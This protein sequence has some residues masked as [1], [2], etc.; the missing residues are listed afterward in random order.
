MRARP[1]FVVCCAFVA[2]A[3]M[4]MGT[5]RA[6]NRT[7]SGPREVSSD[8]RLGPL[9]TLN[10]EFSFVPSPTPEAWASRAA[11]LR[12]QIQVALGLWP[13]PDRPPLKPVIHGA[14]T[15]EGYTVER[16]YFQSLP[17]FFVTG[18]LYRPTGRTGKLPAVLSPHGHWASFISSEISSARQS[19]A[20]R[21][22]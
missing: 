1:R 17:G 7:A 3:A 6:Q 18:S 14:V 20:P 21:K 4:A 15:R 16:V 10:G 5:G 13:M 19:S 12:Q 9:K 2:L 22:T 8:R 11:A